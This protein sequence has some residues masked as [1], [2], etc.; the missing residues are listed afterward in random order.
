[1]VIAVAARP[2]AEELPLFDEVRALCGASRWLTMHR[3]AVVAA[4]GLPKDAMKAGD[5]GATSWMDEPED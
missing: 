2:S 3:R 4:L 1:V 5:A